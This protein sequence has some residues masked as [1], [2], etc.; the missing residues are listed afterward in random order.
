MTKLNGVASTELNGVVYNMEID[1]IELSSPHLTFLYIK[2][3]KTIKAV[4]GAKRYKWQKEGKSLPSV[5]GLIG[6]QKRCDFRSCLNSAK[7]IQKPG[8]S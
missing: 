3:P 2:T 1:G 8:T 5:C 6:L 7:P 4:F